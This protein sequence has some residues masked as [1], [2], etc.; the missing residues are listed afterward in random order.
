MKTI[1]REL[2][3]GKESTEIFEGLSELIKDIKAGKDVAI[4]ATENLPSL[5]TMVDGYDKVSGEMSAKERNATI[6]H[7]LYVLSE[8]LAPVEA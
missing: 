1:K 5:V 4:I 6:A 8:A 2:Q 3:V 7:G